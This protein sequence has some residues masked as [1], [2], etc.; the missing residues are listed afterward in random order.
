MATHRMKLPEVQAVQ[1]TGGNT[2]EVESSLGRSVRVDDTTL[3]LPNDPN[4]IVVPIDH[5]IVVDERQRV[6]LL[7]DADFQVSYEPIV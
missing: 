7:T 5:W 2:S 3:Y 6:N 4:E 1:W